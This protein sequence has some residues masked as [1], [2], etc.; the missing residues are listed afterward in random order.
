MQ[1]IDTQKYTLNMGSLFAGI[2]GFELGIEKAMP[3]VNTLWQCEQDKYCQHVLQHHWPNATMFDDVRNINTNI[4]RPI[5]ILC[6]GFPCQDISIAGNKKG[7]VKNETR[8][9]LWWE[10]H[11][12]TS[13][14]RPH[15]VFMENVSAIS[16][17]GLDTVTASLTEI[18]YVTEWQTV[19]ASHLGAPHQRE[20]WFAVAY[21]IELYE[22]TKQRLDTYTNSH[23]HSIT[24]KTTTSHSISAIELTN[25]LTNRQRQ[26]TIHDH[27]LDN[28]QC[29]QTTQHHTTNTDLQR[30]QKR[31]QPT[32]SNDLQKE[33]KSGR[34]HV[35]TSRVRQAHYHDGW[36]HF[37]TQPP[38]CRRDDGLSYQPHSSTIMANKTMK[39]ARLKALGNAIVPQ[40]AQWVAQQ[41]LISGLIETIWE[42]KNEQHQSK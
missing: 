7:I 38:L 22:R 34:K 36:R 2:G 33:H 18:G 37:P 31:H 12:I 40:C 26:Q 6:G 14:F 39:L 24:Q 11:R 9:G 13:D 3:F 17:R 10:M 4:A 32:Q 42:I 20:R 1:H 30:S 29:H 28:L 23:K 41:V 19:R 16:I 27:G 5:D 35:Q 25:L 21:P 8:S 15:I